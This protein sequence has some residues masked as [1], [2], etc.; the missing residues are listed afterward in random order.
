MQAGWYVSKPANPTVTR[1]GKLRKTTF[2]ILFVCFST[3]PLVVAQ[4][5][6]DGAARVTRI[7]GSVEIMEPGQP[8]APAEVDGKIPLEAIVSTGFR[9]SAAI[10]LNDVA[11]LEIGPLTRIALTELVARDDALVADLYL[12]FG[13]I[14]ASVQTAEGVD[15]DFT[16]RT[17]MS[18]ASVR[19]TRFI[20]DGELWR[21]T[22][23]VV[24]VSN[25][26]GEEVLITVDE[27][28]E[29]IGTALPLDPQR[30]QERDYATVIATNPLDV[31]REERLRFADSTLTATR[32]TVV[33]TF[34]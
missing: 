10:T 7:T 26:R 21:V 3:S 4:T 22:E 23:G 6:S 15:H 9:S 2:L 28:T 30:A 27:R 8:W 17:T 25:R 32:A 18:V 24:S 20:G 5:N 16:I 29:V 31:E 11:V 14:D 13:R 1:V 19:G 12:D 34:E 33:I